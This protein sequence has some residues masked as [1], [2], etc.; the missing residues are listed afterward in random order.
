MHHALSNDGT[1]NAALSVNAAIGNWYLRS[2]SAHRD[3]TVVEAYSQLQ[4]ETD[5]LYT[6]LTRD[7]FPWA[8]HVVF[9][10]CCQP[11]ESDVELIHT[12]YAPTELSRSP[13]PPQ[14][15]SAFIRSW[16]VSSAARLTGSA[17]S[18]ISLV[19]PG[20]D[21]ALISPTSV[22]LGTLKTDFTVVS[23]DTL[24]LPRSLE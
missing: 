23:H 6:V 12:G 20:A 3:P 18:T 1:P 11:Y 2:Q 21:T 17:L 10:R 5:H 7:D 22:R 24:S 13:Q 19:M 14:S 15:E 16:A 9:T 8:A 4:A